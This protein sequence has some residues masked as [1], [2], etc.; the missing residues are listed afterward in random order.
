MRTE[1]ASTHP[2]LFAAVRGPSAAA[3]WAVFV[4]RYTP[5]VDERC[6]A[7]GLQPADAADVRQ[8]VF[9]QLVKALVGFRYDPARKFRGYLTSVVKN[10]IRTHW[11]VLR[12]V[13]GSAAWGD[14]GLPE[15][16]AAL[17]A[18]L[19]DDIRGSLGE[20]SRV[21]ELVRFEVGPEAWAAFWLTAVDGL[22][23]AEAAAQLG[24]QPSAVYMAKSRVLAR[25]RAAHDPGLP[26]R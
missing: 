8:Q 17:P 9:A 26:N 6:R 23:G 21:T 13:P 11:R 5:L 15:P 4:E 12:R 20:L 16:L 10:A 1:E 18:E 24:K 22:S 2:S 7:A 19:D 14:G 3:S 25:L